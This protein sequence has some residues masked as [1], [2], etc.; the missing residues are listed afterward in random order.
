MEVKDMVVWRKLPKCSLVVQAALLLALATAGCNGD[1]APVVPSVLTG[2][3]DSHYFREKGITSYGFIP[4]DLSEE[5]DRREH[6]VNERIST[7]NL[8]QGTH[9]LIEILQTLDTE[10]RHDAESQSEKK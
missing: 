9:R 3:T 4:F 10:A 2:F 5:E 6:G 1:G 8:R 7:Q